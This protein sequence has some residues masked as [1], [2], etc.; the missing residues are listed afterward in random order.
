MIFLY[1]YFLIGV[2]YGFFF[3]FMAE[4]HKSL[5]AMENRTKFFM[6]SVVLWPLG[7][8]IWVLVFVY[9]IALAMKRLLYDR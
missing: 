5:F 9:H 3:D 2:L 8:S 1:I 6:A 7:L 4:R